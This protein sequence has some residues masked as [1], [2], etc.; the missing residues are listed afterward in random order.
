MGTWGTGI[1]SNDIALD[2]KPAITALT[3]LPFTPDQIVDHLCELFPEVATNEGD[4]DY[5]TFWFV[6]A[7][8]LNKKGIASERAS[9]VALDI[10]IS[11]R[12]IE[13]LRNCGMSERDLIMRR[14]VLEKLETDLLRQPKKLVKLAKIKNP[15]PLVLLV[16]ET[17][18]YP[19]SKGESVNPY[20]SPNELK[21][22]PFEPDGFGLFTVIRTGRIFG[23]LPWYQLALSN[24]NLKTLPIQSKLLKTANWSSHGIGTLSAIHKERLM[25]QKLGTFQIKESAINSF[26]P[27]TESDARDSAVS[28]ISIANLLRTDISGSPRRFFDFF[29]A[30]PS[31]TILSNFL[32]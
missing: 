18:A 13:T 31:S 25:L 23:F 24:Q 5:S 8:Q 4:E 27:F 19:T 12:D 32:A 9:K 22:L 3:K 10:M 1:Y 2:I 30:S 26:F 6:L 14:K 16:G 28:D 11:G 21:K 29:S 17:Y 15:K 7:D 20:F